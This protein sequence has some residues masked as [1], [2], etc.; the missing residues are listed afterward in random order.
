MVLNID[1]DAVQDEQKMHD[2]LEHYLRY[3]KRGLFGFALPGA[4]YAAL[5]KK[6]VLAGCTSSEILLQILERGL[7][8]KI[9]AELD[10]EDSLETNLITTKEYAAR[11]E[12]SKEQIKQY[13]HQRGRVPDALRI[14]RD[15][16]IPMDAEFPEDLRGK[17]KCPEEGVKEELRE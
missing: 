7:G 4:V 13:L 3:E 1:Y 10:V 2:Y 17:R 12:K 16:V 5:E 15:W 14:G 6:A 11:H 9:N 8:D